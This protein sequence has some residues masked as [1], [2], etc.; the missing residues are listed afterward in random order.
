MED[1][2]KKNTHTHTHTLNLNTKNTFQIKETCNIRHALPA[3]QY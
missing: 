2:V 1:F 3:M